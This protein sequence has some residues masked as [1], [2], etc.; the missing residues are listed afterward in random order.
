MPGSTFYPQYESALVYREQ[1][2]WLV[3]FTFPEHDKKTHG[4]RISIG[5]SAF[6]PLLSGNH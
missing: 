5:F 2:G 6:N 3:S 1:A 4:V